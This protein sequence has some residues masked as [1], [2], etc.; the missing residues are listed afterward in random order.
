[1]LLTRAIGPALAAEPPGTEL[2]NAAI[3]ECDAIADRPSKTDRAAL[4]AARQTAERAVAADP[5]DAKAHLAMFCVIAKLASL[6]RFRLSGLFAVRRLH[7][8]VD[9]ALALAPDYEDALIAK[10]AL[11][12]NLPGLLGGDAHEAARLLQR[13]VELEPERISARLHLAEAYEKTGRPADAKQ[14]AERALQ[15]AEAAGR[16]AQAEEAR[17]RLKKQ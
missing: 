11:L 4:E 5:K 12:L 2:S 16:T 3:R 7:S 17:R 1:M 15:L 9:R 13:A 6:D 14:Q 10:G 8:E